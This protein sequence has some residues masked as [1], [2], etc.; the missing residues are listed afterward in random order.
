MRI[1]KSVEVT[2]NEQFLVGSLCNKC[3]EVF[4]PHDDKIQSF[5]LQLGYHNWQYELCDDCIVDMVRSFLIVPSGF[6]SDP[7]FTSSFDID[8]EL[9]QN[10]F[11]EWKL[12]GKWNCDENPWRDFYS[13][14]NSDQEFESYEEYYEEI[15][16]AIEV[17]KPLRINVVRLA[18]IHK[19]GLVKERGNKIK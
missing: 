2:K 14:D 15:S 4:E 3:G 9:H 5:N 1:T 13:E 12:S 7:N 11:D 19:I 18:T 16:N 17:R 8:H 6:M 10:L